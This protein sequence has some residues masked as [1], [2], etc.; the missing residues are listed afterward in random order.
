M[1]R[2][3]SQNLTLPSRLSSWFLVISI[4]GLS[5]DA[6]AQSTGRLYDPE[7]PID[8]GYV[9]VIL[10]SRD[11]PMDVLVDGQPRVRK[12][13]SQEL[14][15]YM[16]L[17][18]GKHTIALNPVDKPGAVF[19]RSIDVARGK[20][21]TL[22]VSALKQDATLFSYEDKG[23]TNKLKSVLM[24]YHLDP[25]AGSLD[26][27]TGD[28]GTK[29]FGGLAYGATA[30]IQVNPIVVDIIV[31]SI[32]DKSAKS[33]ST[34]EMQQGG[35]YSVLLLGANGNKIIMKTTQNRTERYAVK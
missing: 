13:A 18:E 6:V 26:I 31:T 24:A 22:A 10:A 9:R 20:A 4:V 23:N 16:V 3:F 27:L 30:S 25:K 17:T 5:M 32:G 7:P 11:A 8:S 19:S 21:V 1:S 12:L 33:R 34:L 2:S 29:V 14:S 35:T 15:E 28:G